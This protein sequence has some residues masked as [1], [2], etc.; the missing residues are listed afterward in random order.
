MPVVTITSSPDARPSE[1][2]NV[3]RTSGRKKT[4]YVLIKCELIRF[5]EE[6]YIQLENLKFQVENANMLTHLVGV[7]D[8]GERLRTTDGGI[9]LISERREKFKKLYDTHFSSACCNSLSRLL[10]L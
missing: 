6:G 9:R 4:N 5:K 1:K 3:G 8:F 2:V 10:S 7:Y